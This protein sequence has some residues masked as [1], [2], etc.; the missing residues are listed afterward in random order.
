MYI[1]RS[2]ITH[3]LT[4]KKITIKIEKKTLIEDLFDATKFC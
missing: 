1:S 3:A 2:M 4:Y